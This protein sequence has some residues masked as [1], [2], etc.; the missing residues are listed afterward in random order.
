MSAAELE[1]IVSSV[2]SAGMVVSPSTL[3]WNWQSAGR[4]YRA[5][6]HPGSIC[7]SPGGPFPRQWWA[8]PVTI[9]T[10]C[11]EPDFLYGSLQEPDSYPRLELI[12]SPT[13]TDPVI[14]HLF[15]ALHA[16]I[17]GGFP[18]GRMVAESVA[19][20]LAGALCQRRQVQHAR[21]L[22]HRG[23]LSRKTLTKVTDYIYEN[24][25]QNLGIR[26]LAQLAGLSHFHF[27][28]QF[29]TSAGRTVHDYILA[30]RMERAK[31]LLSKTDLPIAEVAYQS[32]MPNLS[33]F[34]TAFRKN[35]GATPAAFRLHTKF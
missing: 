11:F 2:P 33:H 10:V 20:A 29:K 18:S 19:S 21:P 27:C 3:D 17:R 35:V 30:L 26:E 5:L 12:L 9:L 34:S 14:S 25:N 24:A 16:E 13:G 4:D 7:T 1:P 28:R 32:G 6:F 23:G 15:W 22:P 8:E 31:H